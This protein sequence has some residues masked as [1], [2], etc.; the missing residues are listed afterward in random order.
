ML[1]HAVGHDE[2][3]PL[4]QTHAVHVECRQI[5]RRRQMMIRIAQHLER[6]MQALR[7]FKLI[8]GGLRA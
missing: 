4:D 5:E 7:H 6:Q 8:G 2:R 3:Q 1:D